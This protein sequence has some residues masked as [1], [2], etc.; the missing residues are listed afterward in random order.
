MH[1]PLS[2]DRFRN[3]IGSILKRYARSL[4]T[5]RYSRDIY[6][7]LLPGPVLR[8]LWS[9][10][11]KLRSERLFASPPKKGPPHHY[12]SINQKAEEAKASEHS[13]LQH[14]KYHRPRRTYTSKV[15]QSL[16]I[17]ISFFFVTSLYRHNN[18][19][20]PRSPSLA[21]LSVWSNDHTA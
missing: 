19:S 9:H 7:L 8:T 18:P 6:C 17:R 16:R 21:L 3:Q 12:K 5:Y 11:V 10:Y 14:T 15:I 13:F 1:V 4:L 20:M 2:V